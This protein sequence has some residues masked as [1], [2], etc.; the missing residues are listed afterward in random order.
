MV[1][2][3]PGTF[4]MWAARHQVE[5]ALQKVVGMTLLA[6]NAQDHSGPE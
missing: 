1:T 5:T 6:N 2:R 4:A 3:R